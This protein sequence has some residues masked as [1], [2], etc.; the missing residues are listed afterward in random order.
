MPWPAYWKPHLWMTRRDAGLMTRHEACST[1]TLVA[2]KPRST[3]A[4]AASVAKPFFQY[5]SP[6]Q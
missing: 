2:L 3:S 4:W 6:I 1:F 5:G